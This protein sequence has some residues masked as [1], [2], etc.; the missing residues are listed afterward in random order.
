MERFLACVTR[1]TMWLLLSHSAL[2]GAQRRRSRKKLGAKWS[3]HE[4]VDGNKT[5]KHQLRPEASY[6][7]GI[8]V[9]ESDKLFFTD[10]RTLKCHT[11]LLQ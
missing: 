6:G 2:G 7:A 11:T 10:K 9:S 1:Q 5:T 4:V 3:T 8:D